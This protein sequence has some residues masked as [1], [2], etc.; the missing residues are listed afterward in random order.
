[1]IDTSRAVTVARPSSRRDGSRQP[2]TKRA[3]TATTHVSV[4]IS[5]LTSTEAEPQTVPAP[6]RVEGDD[7]VDERRDGPRPL[8]T[9]AGEDVGTG[10]LVHQRGRGIR[11]ER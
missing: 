7:E 1:V 8:T 6:E 10:D 11:I 3:S 4:T 9:E 5:G 2:A